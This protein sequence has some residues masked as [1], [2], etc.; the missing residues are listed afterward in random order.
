MDSSRRSGIPVPTA[1]MGN[2]K[3]SISKS[4]D[5]LLSESNDFQSPNGDL[6]VFTLLEENIAL[7]EK[8]EN[9][10]T[11]NHA[12]KQFCSSAALCGNTS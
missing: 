8:T 4:T 7:K 11:K 6:D 10:S 9:L 3:K 12:S 1:K 5:D 2:P